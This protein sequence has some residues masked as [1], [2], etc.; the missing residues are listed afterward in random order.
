VLLAEM[1]Q[2][3]TVSQRDKDECMA[4]KTVRR[5]LLLAPMIHA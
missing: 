5:R 1:H 4:L 2:G 3:P